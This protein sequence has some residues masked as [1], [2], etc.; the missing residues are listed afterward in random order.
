[1]RTQLQAEM[2]D[3]YANAAAKT[4]AMVGEAD[5]FSGF[6]GGRAKPRSGS[7]MTRCLSSGLAA[8]S[9]SASPSSLGRSANNSVGQLL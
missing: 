6:A 1:M 3:A 2:K 4:A 7:M 9:G 5:I 8:R